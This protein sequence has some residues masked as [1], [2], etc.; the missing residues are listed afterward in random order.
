MA[1]TLFV[2]SIWR[3][4]SYET[5]Q[6]TIPVR[7]ENWQTLWSFRVPRS[8]DQSWGCLVSCTF[9]IDPGAVGDVRIRSAAGGD[10]SAA[11]R[12]ESF[13][14]PVLL[15]IETLTWA[16]TVEQYVHLEGRRSGGLAGL[17]LVD[18]PALTP[19]S[20]IPSQFLNLP[21]YPGDYTGGSG[22]TGTY[23]PDY[24]TDPYS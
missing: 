18:K 16:G 20:L 14:G 9:D 2:P 24:T 23:P 15:G 7:S 19:I 1:E 11:A 5:E 3:A 21:M 12:I 13:V 6:A 8:S 4:W 10:V 17:K 22:Q